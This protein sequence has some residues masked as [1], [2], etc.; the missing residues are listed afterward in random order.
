M[1]FNSRFKVLINHSRK[2]N[3]S[4]YG[5]FSQPLVI[6]KIPFAGD[7]F[8]FKRFRSQSPTLIRKFRSKSTTFYLIN[9]VRSQ[10]LF[11]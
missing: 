9:T 6:L 7:H 3:A 1:G 5:V 4:A 2:R 11:T 8:L 10:P